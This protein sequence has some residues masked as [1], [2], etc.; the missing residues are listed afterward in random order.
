VRRWLD[1]LFHPPMPYMAGLLK[2]PVRTERERGHLRREM[3][4][5]RRTAV[6][7]K[8]LAASESVMGGF[9]NDVAPEQLTETLRAAG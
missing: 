5:S 2:A 8:H 9:I 1:G 7:L 4:S 6:K 3:V